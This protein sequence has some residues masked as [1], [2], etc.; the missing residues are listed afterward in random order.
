MP[1]MH[2]D[3]LWPNGQHETCYSP[4]TVIQQHLQVGKEYDLSDFVQLSQIA[5]NEA[6]ERV[7]AKFGYYCSSAIHQ[8][9][10]IE[11]RAKQFEQHAEP[12]VIVQAIRPA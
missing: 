7:K 11:Q 9:D 10:T 8:L 5:L 12:K 3:V 1:D 2:F 4:S 6:S